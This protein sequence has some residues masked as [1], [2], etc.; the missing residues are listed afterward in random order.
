MLDFFFLIFAVN[1]VAC[2]TL[3]NIIGTDFLVMTTE[4]FY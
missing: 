4:V 2:N 1:P 3:R